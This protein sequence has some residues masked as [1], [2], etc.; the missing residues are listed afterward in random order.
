MPWPPARMREP[1]VGKAI[2]LPGGRGSPIEP[3]YCA[4]QVNSTTSMEEVTVPLAFTVV[5]IRMCCLPSDPSE[6]WTTT[7]S[8]LV[9]TAFLGFV[10]TLDD[11]AREP[12]KLAWLGSSGTK[13]T[14]P[15][16]VT[17]S[18][19]VPSPRSVI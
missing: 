16:V 3:P 19:T 4:R 17:V 11:S 14:V 5:W 7:F 15:V 10:I 8:A 12:L 1:V 9:V 2:G 18:W 13:V 6:P